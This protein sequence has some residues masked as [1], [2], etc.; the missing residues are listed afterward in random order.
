MAARA[1]V[2]PAAGLAVTAARRRRPVPGAATGPARA[3]APRRRER[4]GGQPDELLG[5]LSRALEPGVGRLLAGVGRARHVE[6]A[7]VDRDGDP[8]PQQAQGVGGAARAHVAALGRT[9]APGL[10]GQQG[11][12]DALVKVLHA[13]EQARVAGEVDGRRTVHDEAQ[14]LGRQRDDPAPPRVA[15]V[16]RL[17]LD[18]AEV[19]RRVATRLDDRLEARPG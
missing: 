19:Q 15:G 8:R 7:P 4:L 16:H 6:R 3:A 10:D 5:T 12:V 11:Q 1:P 13:V 9:H 14:R 18:G 17:D 2:R